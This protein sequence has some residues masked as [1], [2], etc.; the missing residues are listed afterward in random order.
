MKRVYD[1]QIRVIRSTDTELCLKML[2]QLSKKLGAKFPSTT[3]SY[4]MVRIERLTVAFSGIFELEASPVESQ[5]MQLKDKKRR[6][7]AK[8]ISIWVH[9]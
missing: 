2:R 4:S 1:I 3:L 6:K 7:T 9:A 8:R 5:S